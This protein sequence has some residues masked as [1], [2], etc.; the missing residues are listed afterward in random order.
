MKEERESWERD[1]D[2]ERRE[3]KEMAVGLCRNGTGWTH[4]AVGLAGFY[5][6]SPARVSRDL[7]AA[8][9][10]PMEPINSF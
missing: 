9:I 10:F 5:A 7:P 1:R 3:R 2:S 4:D 6:S 8:V